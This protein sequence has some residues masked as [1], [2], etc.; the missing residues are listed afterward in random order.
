VW[1]LLRT[2][3]GRF[4][5]S[6]SAD[7]ANWSEPCP[8]GIVSSESPAGLV[9]LNDGRLLLL[10]NN[11]ER[12]PYA[13]G[14]R[15][16]LHAAISEDEGA[17]WHGY[18]EVV[19]DPLR[20]QPPPTHGD[21]GAAYPFPALTDAG[22]VI[23]TLGVAS[24]TRS[25]WPEGLDGPPHDEQRSAL[26][27]DP[28]WLDETAQS[29]DFSHGLDDWSTFGVK[30]A[31]L[32]AHPDKSNAQVLRISKPD[33]QWPSGAVWNFP[34]GPEGNLH[35]RVLLKTGSLGMLVGLTDH[36][37]VPWD[38]EDRFHNIFNFNLQPG[39]SLGTGRWHDV[40]L[41]WNCGRRECRV[42]IDGHAGG[43]LS[44]MREPQ[45]HGICYLRLRSAAPHIDTAGTLVESV[46]AGVSPR[47]AR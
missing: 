24:G 32:I 43:I 13:F 47:H 3:M 25:Q 34:A 39:A 11:A 19:R 36:F 17:S 42:K 20:N 7:G 31:D 18:R 16:V 37:S 28:A 4:Y 6:L 27:F 8:T 22:R 29:T 14:G 2:E 10:V 33:E 21:F 41:A 40:E 9:R 38:P 35:F 26:R 30:G 45:S 44:Q 12:F 1:M 46:S 15:H 5:E 23:F